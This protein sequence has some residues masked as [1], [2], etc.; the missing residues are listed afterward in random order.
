MTHAD[1]LDRFFEIFLC[2]QKIDK[3]SGM[4]FSISPFHQLHIDLDLSSNLSFSPKRPLPQKGNTFSR[5][6]GGGQFQ[7][8]NAKV[9]DGGDAGD[10]WDTL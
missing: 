3:A 8:L 7:Q 10:G 9:D 5:Y 6:S 4:L 1:R 2:S